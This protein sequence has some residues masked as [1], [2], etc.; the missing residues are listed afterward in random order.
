MIIL[1]LNFVHLNE[2][3]LHADLNEKEKKTNHFW[4]ICREICKGAVG[5]QPQL[6]ERVQEESSF[7]SAFVAVQ[8]IESCFRFYFG[9]GSRSSV[10]AGTG[11]SVR[12]VESHV[13]IAVEI[14]S[15]A[16]R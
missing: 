5:R 7:N 3:N 10:A 9:K 15:V 2:F 6:Q 12:L 11:I 14:H 4:V 16:G 8:K 1:T 13:E